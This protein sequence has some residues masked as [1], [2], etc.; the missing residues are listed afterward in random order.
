MKGEQMKRGTKR[1]NGKFEVVSVSENLIPESKDKKFRGY[2]FRSERNMIVLSRGR[3][4]SGEDTLAI[5]GEFCKT[6]S[7]DGENI[8]DA[9]RVNSEIRATLGIA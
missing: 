6:Y 8:P 7:G 9:R 4:F 3:V 2:T 5:A 1:N